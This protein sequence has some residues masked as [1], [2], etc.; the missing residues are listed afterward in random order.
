MTAIFAASIDTAVAVDSDGETVVSL[1]LPSR[2]A[3]YLLMA[4]LNLVSQS[5]AVAHCSI[6]PD[7]GGASDSIEIRLGSDFDTSNYLVLPHAYT[8][9]SAAP[10]LECSSDAGGTFT[11]KSRTHRRDR[12]PDALDGAVARAHARNIARGERLATE[13]VFPRAF[14]PIRKACF[15]FASSSAS[16]SSHR[17]FACRGQSSSGRRSRRPTRS[18]SR[19]TAFARSAAR[20][21]SESLPPRLR[22]ERLRS[23]GEHRRARHDRLHS[24]VERGGQPARRPRGAAR[25]ASRRA[26]ARR[27]RRLDRPDS[28]SRAPTTG[29]RCSRSAQPRSAAPASRR[30]TRTLRSRATPIA[31][32]STPTGSTR[33]PSCGACSSSCAPGECDV[34]VGSRFVSRRRLRALSLRARPA[35]AS[36][37]PGCCAAGCRSRSAGRF[38]TRRAVSTRRT[39]RR[40]RSSRS[41]TRAARPR[42]RRSS[43][44]TERPARARGPGRHARTRVGRVE[45]AWEEGAAARDHGHRHAAPARVACAVAAD[46]TRVVAVLGYSRRGD[47]V[48]HDICLQRLRRAE[49]ISQPTDAVVLSGRG[50]ARGGSEAALMAAAWRG[51]TACTSCRRPSPG[52]RSAT[53]AR[54]LVTPARSGRTKWS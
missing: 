19:L 37:A 41:R 47:S 43:G 48:I 29:R 46:T 42:W 38:T 17:C 11:V 44:S 23:P 53:R 4:K 39:R 33:R 14:L 35:S 25:R 32:A 31:A 20:T 10:A 54:S 1:T 7:D 49:D 51:D 8:A 16:A 15:V 52:R 26:R 40:S 2:P 50:R 21:D 27:R 30:A 13:L 6:D 34:A 24:R 5:G 22:T 28:G 18:P 45:A 9:G 36:S 3:S 12:E